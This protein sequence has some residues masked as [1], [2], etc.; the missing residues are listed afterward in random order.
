MIL[1]VAAAEDSLVEAAGVAAEGKKVKAARLLMDAQARAQAVHDDLYATYD[2][3]KAVWEKSRYP[4]GRSVGDR[5]F[6]HVMDDVKDHLA[7]RR[8]DLS[9]L[10]S[11]EENI[12]LANWLVDLRKIAEA[13]MAAQGLTMAAV[14]ERH[15]EE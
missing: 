2:N 14:M 3:L 13:Y 15:S 5:N 9:Y 11:P 7:D 8:P 4:K 1:S 6:V 10:I 12:G